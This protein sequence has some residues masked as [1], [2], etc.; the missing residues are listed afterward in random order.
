MK[1]GL[2]ILILLLIVPIVLAQEELVSTVENQLS[3]EFH[4]VSGNDIITL[5]LPRY[6]G[7][8]ANFVSNNPV[9]VE[10]T[11]D[12]VTHFAT[13][14]SKDP[15][16]RGIETV[17][18][19]TETKYLEDDG[20]K[21]GFILPYA[22]TK[23][24]L[25][26]NVSKDQVAL[27]TDA[28]TQ[29][30]FETVLGNLTGEPIDIKTFITNNSLSLEINNEL[31]FNIS[32][33]NDKPK[34]NMMWQL[35]PNQNMTVGYYSEK[36]D[37]LTFTLIIFILFAFVVLIL[38]VIYGYSDQIKETIFA[39]KILRTDVR[40]RILKNKKEAKNKLT[41]IQK[42]VGK[43]KLSKLYKECND[44]MNKFLAKGLGITGADS[45]KVR[46]KLNKIGIGVGAAAQIT[47]FMVERKTKLFEGRDLTEDDLNNYISFLKSILRKI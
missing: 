11:I 46:D 24:K 3:L 7:K 17:V 15:E 16:W 29:M 26:L 25:L 33:E 39:P 36:P 40:N 12:P 8:D 30:Q 14:K 43:E 27:E 37:I 2:F 10:V 42:R 35:R 4:A 9:N 44:V 19:A 23:E 32:F 5:D 41:L 22:P 34:L 45:Q 21:K 20:E 18:F 13:L 38:Y 28:F 6:F 1:R 47:N 31:L